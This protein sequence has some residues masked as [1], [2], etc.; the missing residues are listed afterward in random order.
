GERIR[1]EKEQVF[2]KGARLRHYGAIGADDHAGAIKHQLIIAADLVHHH[3]R[4]LVFT[5]DGLQHLAAQLALPYPKWRGRN[6]QHEISALPHQL[7]YWIHAV[8]PPVPE[9]LIIPCVFANRK[10]HALSAK[11]KQ[12]LL[13]RGCE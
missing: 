2:L 3:N 9:L 4:S 8:E 7:L 13:L 10:R 5:R 11:R 6:V 1:I 12:R